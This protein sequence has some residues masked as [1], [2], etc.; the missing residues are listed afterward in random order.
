M[1]DDEPQP[2]AQPDGPTPSRVCSRCSTVSQT[3]GDFCPQCGKSYLRRSIRW[4]GWSKR[5]RIVVAA[6]V[7]IVILGGGGTAVAL[8]VSADRAEDRRQA[9]AARKAEE[10]RQAAAERERQAQEEAEAAEEYE[11]DVRK[12][13]AELV[14]SLRKSITEDARKRV[15][16]GYLEGPIISTSCENSDGNERDLD[17]ENGAYECLAA[18]IKRD[19]GQVEGYRFS[20]RVDYEDGSY[21]WRLGS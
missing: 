5:V 6:A 11:R 21:T 16:E 19:D 4:S 9:D 13:R 18:N 12:L 14:R 1:I 7:A 10:Q 15:N 17:A 3:T 20:G 8:K 2:G